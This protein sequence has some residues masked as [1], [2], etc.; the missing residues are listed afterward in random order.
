MAFPLTTRL[1][2]EYDDAFTED[3]MLI[4]SLQSKTAQ[5]TTSLSIWRDE[6]KEDG[7]SEDGILNYSTA[8]YLNKKYI[9]GQLYS[10][11]FHFTPTSMTSKAMR[12]LAQSGVFTIDGQPSDR[13]SRSFLSFAVALD[14]RTS[15]C[16][17]DMLALLHHDGFTVTATHVK[18]T[19]AQYQTIFTTE[20]FTYR[21]RYVPI[22]E[23]K[24]LNDFALK[25]NPTFGRLQNVNCALHHPLLVLDR[26]NEMFKF[27][28]SNYFMCSVWNADWNEKQADQSLLYRWFWFVFEHLHMPP[29]E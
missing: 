22:A 4:D 3:I 29:M 18:D 20:G 10:T 26:F 14:E 27:D 6:I 16:F 9:E 8:L 7:V 13:E 17:I 21:N 23:V 11:L 24:E 28:K 2:A 19:K 1:I 12:Q 15:E 25:L 5:I